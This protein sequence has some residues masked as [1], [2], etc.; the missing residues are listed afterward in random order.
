MESNLALR[1]EKSVRLS[2][3]ELKKLKAY[4]KG[5]N[6]AISCAEAIGIPR[7]VLLRIL[8]VGSGSPDNISKVTEAIGSANK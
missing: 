8:L 6:T 5:F 3:D 7:T 2:R 4:R 1:K